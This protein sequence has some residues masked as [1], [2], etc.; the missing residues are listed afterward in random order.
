MRIL[1][2]AFLAALVSPLTASAGEPTTGVAE[3]LSSTHVCDG[4]TNSSQTPTDVTESSGTEKYR[5]VTVQNQNTAA[6]LYCSGNVAVSTI[7]AN[8]TLGV[9]ISSNTPANIERTFTLVPGEKW[10]C[11]GNLTTASTRAA[12]C[13]GR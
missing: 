11:L 6:S 8:A 3:Q 13:R 5:F 2:L 10:Y 4:I 9:L 1:V 7:A 12:V